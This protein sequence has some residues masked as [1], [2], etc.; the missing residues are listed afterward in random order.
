MAPIPSTSTEP[1]GNEALHAFLTS[2]EPTTHRL[3]NVIGLPLRV[4][5]LAHGTGSASCVPPAILDLLGLDAR[6]TVFTRRSELVTPGGTPVSRN[7]VITRAALPPHLVGALTDEGIPL[8]RG[9]LVQ[10]EER[11]RELVSTGSAPW[12]DGDGPVRHTPR[13]DYLIHLR[14][15]A[16]V[17]VAEHFGPA[18]VGAV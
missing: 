18:L 12:A 14:S 9:P 13:R 4:T 2:T 8:G 15:T 7:T 17:Y 6:H 16:T 3:E 11:S 10:C 5:V 1:V